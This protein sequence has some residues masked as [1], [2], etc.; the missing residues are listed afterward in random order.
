M[1]VFALSDQIVEDYSAFSRSFTP[2]RS[3][4]VR[5]YVD[6]EY[7]SGRFWPEPLIQINP[8]FKSGGLI[9][10]IVNDGLLHPDAGHIFRKEGKPLRLHL[11]QKQAISRA[12][13]GQS[14]VV[15]TGTGSGKSLC[16]LVPI[17]DHILRTKSEG[18]KKSTC[19]IVIYPM[20][21]L[22]N[23]QI[24]EAEK[25]L[26][27]FDG[28]NKPRVKRY[29]GQE[30]TDD[31]AEIA[32]NP[33]DV[34]LTNFMMLEYLLTRRASQ[35]EQV[36]SNCEGL[37]F[38]VL[39]ELHT[40]RGRQGADVAMLVRRVRERL[41]TDDNLICIGTSATMSS[42]GDSME[43]RQTVANVAS[44]L[45]ATK[46]PPENVLVEA[47]ERRTQLPA[48]IP[49]S[50]LVEMVTR[51]TPAAMTD[52]VMA[53]DPM[54]VWI[55]T[56][57]GLNKLDSGDPERQ[58]PV[59]LR[60]ASTLLHDECGEPLDRCRTALSDFLLLASKGEKD[61]GGAPTGEA[62]FFPFRLHRFLSG[63]G[64][65]HATLEPRGRRKFFFDGQVYAPEREE[66]DE[67]RLFGT[68]FCRRCGHEHHPVYKIR[69]DEVAFRAREIDDMPDE[70]EA[71]DPEA[72]QVAG[73]L[74]PVPPTEEEWTFNGEVADYP[75]N[76][77][78]DKGS[79]LIPT[80][81]KRAG[82]LVSLTPLGSQSASGASLWFFPG[83]HR[84]C[85]CCGTANN[86]QGRDMTHLAGITS[87]GRSSATTVLVTSLLEWLNEHSGLEQSRR[88]VLAFT[89][90]RQDAALQAG[91]FNDSVFVTILRAGF[92]SAVTAAGSSGL[93]GDK[94]GKAIQ[95]ALRFTQADP[96]RFDDWILDAGQG[97]KLS[98]TAIEDA[99]ETMG[100]M[101]ALRG[102]IDQQ[103]GWR[104]TNP[105]LEDLKLIEVDYRGLQE[106]VQHEAVARHHLLAALTDQK[107]T[108]VVRA[109]LD[110][111]RR[112]V[113][114][115]A[116]VL[117]GSKIDELRQQSVS[118]LRSPWGLGDSER[119]TTSRA[120]II[121]QRP[122]GKSPDDDIE[123]RSG[124]KS[125]LGRRLRSKTEFHW[126]KRLTEPQTQEV[127]EAVFQAAVDTNMLRTSGNGFQIDV[128]RVLFKAVPEATPKNT[129]FA[130]LYR[131]TAAAL[132]GSAA[133]FGFEGREHTAQ[134]TN[135]LRQV[136]EAR[137]RTAD[138]VAI[139]QVMTDQEFDT[140]P[141]PVRF[142]PTLFCSPTMELGVDIADL[143]VVYLRNAPPTP[144]NYAQR[145]GR[146]GRS[147]QA[148]L[149]LTYCSAMSPHDN[150]Y[151]RNKEELVYGVVEPPSL[152][153]VNRELIESHLHST[154]L[155]C[156]KQEFNPSIPQVLDIEMPKR[157]IRTEIAD[158]IT[159]PAV[160]VEAK[161][162]IERVLDTD[163]MQH[164]TPADAPW[165][166]DRAAFV[167]E[168]VRDAPTMLDHAFDRWRNLLADAEQLRE[169]AHV[170]NQDLS[171]PSD[172]RRQATRDY[173][174]AMS[175][176]DA[177]KADGNS[178]ASGDF[179]LYRYL[180]TEGFLPGYN[181]PRLPLRAFI[182]AV[183]S[184]RTFV[185]RARFLAISEFGPNSIIYHEG[186]TFRVHRA[187]LP[188]N[189]SEDG[190]LRLRRLRICKSCGAS[191]SD[192]TLN[193]C[194][195]CGTEL[196]DNSDLITNILPI[197][198]V[199]A[200]P[201]QRI[202][203]NDEER[204]RQG[205]DI[206]TTFNWP[207]RDQGPQFRNAEIDADGTTLARVQFATGATITR[208]NK[209]LKRSATGGAGFSINV[210]NGLW[211]REDDKGDPNQRYAFVV[212]LV[213][214]TKNV[215]LFIPRRSVMAAGGYTTASTILYALVRGIEAE[216]TIE[217]GEILTENMPSRDDRRAFLIY[218][219][220]E[221][222]AGVLSRL[223]RESDAFARVARRALDI[224]HWKFN[225]KPLA[226]ATDAELEQ[227]TVDGLEN[228]DPTCVAGCYRCLLSYFNQPEH[229]HIDRQNAEAL[230]FLVSLA[231]SSLSMTHDGPQRPTARDFAGSG[232]PASAEGLTWEAAAAA[233]GIVVA[234]DNL[235][236]LDGV[237][238]PAS[239]RHAGVI[240]LRDGETADVS[241]VANN[242]IVVVPFAA[243]AAEWPAAF[244]ELKSL[245]G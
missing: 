103:R 3:P 164:L 191:H 100:E 75:E 59:D 34:L 229:E 44:T 106:V 220:V 159:S 93:R 219:A 165:I 188:V 110:H 51:E 47:L 200:R 81:R 87:E 175:Q 92:L 19:A 66:G 118:R 96:D 197:E 57:L 145:S 124:A 74:V 14:F 193:R 195:A 115:N 55:E 141:E 85:A 169:R 192:D 61:R 111:V 138:Q 199:D 53:L 11:H 231:R 9:S 239:W 189:S 173:S 1:D 49:R 135:E 147:G 67:A 21:A 171:Q 230:A 228:D 40:Y 99:E 58:K 73:F 206:Q 64:V 4:D 52:A 208:V 101:L 38:L 232:E 179:Y 68:Y 76:W 105:N 221:G 187:K 223:S 244:S 186:R 120:A 241:K 62:P 33:P 209:G 176:I 48:S 131:M 180:A 23:S 161:R 140:P 37:R 119:I 98:L 20:N 153:L 22:A 117:K 27:Q 215:M 97:K 224:M 142:L 172:K 144:A 216:F 143:N 122:S 204:R 32:R 154:W 84:F 182:P 151:F 167:D 69:G 121:E 109:V 170:I 225:G 243:D 54:S 50:T 123:I 91:H 242:G 79:K 205:F 211:K 149:V 207:V 213:S 24:E 210:A 114:I 78:N 29:T 134:V 45:F 126:P 65:L 155:S 227:L 102:W 133:I 183:G 226:D 185:Q 162:R 174:V 168:L 82:E 63:A 112:V 152:D 234:P 36:I 163:L 201:T 90:N 6:A 5:S 31:R 160:A 25:F 240:A 89:D 130:N 196:T 41:V 108:E 86:G 18:S 218:E 17:V 214:D 202:T 184:R 60:A 116:L 146:A 72:A 233:S 136:R 94:L 198:A 43:R 194:H 203:A 107:R 132:S 222:G 95:D 148:A 125:L 2:I 237:T 217:E 113:A 56:R 12:R 137:F 88:K 157:P 104:Y 178:G 128:G 28:P 245:I 70:D 46:I 181:F 83:K 77:Q 15:T 129:F 177:L 13:N 150:Y 16:Y 156:V 235:I 127:I 35:D 39:D 236:S 139:R 10:D 7:D 238:F 158:A 80:Y 42:K 190:H 166:S 212:P 30:K 71:F 26:R 8:Q